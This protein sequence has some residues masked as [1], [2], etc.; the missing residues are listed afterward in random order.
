MKRKFTRRQAQAGFSL[1]EIIVAM[2]ILALLS[3]AVMTVL[4]RAG[5][6]ASEVRESD[7]RDEELNRFMS[8]LGETIESLP[9]GST[10]TVTAPEDSTSGFHELTIENA[11]TSFDFGRLIGTVE[12]TVIALRPTASP[13]YAAEAAEPLFDLVLSRSDFAPD[14]EDSG[15]MM[16]R[17]GADEW[18]QIDEDGRYWLPLVQGVSTA[19]WRYWDEEQDEWLDL[20]DDEAPPSLLEFSLVDRG[21]IYPMRTIFE[22]PEPH[23][24]AT[25]EAASGAAGGGAGS[26]IN[27]TTQST[28]QNGGR[29]GTGNA[30]QRGDRG[31]GGEGARPGGPRGDGGGK[32]KGGG[33]GRGNPQGG[34]RGNGNGGQP[35]AQP[36]AN[37]S[38]GNPAGGGSQ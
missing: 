16:F 11:S 1:L 5:D 17:G 12:E 25:D 6:I 30:G 14:A 21:R 20:W 29:G 26:A 24:D 38:G 15:G 35:G 13:R 32:G 22:M 7:R 34:G 9:D 37:G 36:G 10:L 28:D 4:Y 33:G 18:M 31:R 3:G 27:R 2:I 23:G 8:L 19:T